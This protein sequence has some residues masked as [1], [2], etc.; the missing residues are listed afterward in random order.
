M[1]EKRVRRDGPPLVAAQ[2]ARL[3]VRR[4]L[5]LRSLAVSV[6]VANV[7]PHHGLTL[8]SVPAL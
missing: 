4:T 5:S 7:V 2:R 3:V 1:S 6:A 8:V